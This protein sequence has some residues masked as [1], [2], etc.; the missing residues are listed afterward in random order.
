MVDCSRTHGRPA[1]VVTLDPDDHTLGV[2]HRN[3]LFSRLPECCPYGVSTGSTGVK[4]TSFRHEAPTGDR[5]TVAP[6]HWPRL[7]PVLYS[8]DT[9]HF[10]LTTVPSLYHGINRI[11]TK[12]SS[13]YCK[14]TKI[15]VKVRQSCE[16]SG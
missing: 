2:S 15:T 5:F 12:Y 8:E 10:P 9:K 3:V 11:N 13:L 16:N 4:P 6:D 7:I 1:A 14:I